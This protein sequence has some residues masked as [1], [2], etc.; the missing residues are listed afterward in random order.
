MLNLNDQ[1]EYFKQLTRFQTDVKKW[2]EENYY[3]D[4][5]NS[6]YRKAEA[7]SK[8]HEEILAAA[9][10]LKHSVEQT[11]LHHAENFKKE[12]NEFLSEDHPVFKELADIRDKLAKASKEYEETNHRVSRLLENLEDQHQ[13]LSTRTVILSNSSSILED[14]YEMKDELKYVRTMFKEKDSFNKDDI[15]TSFEW[16]GISI[17]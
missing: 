16:D 14:I 6:L 13:K 7:V 2:M 12:I 1:E 10:N 17:N 3:P 11:F 4:I 5:H 9:K 15:W 8:Q